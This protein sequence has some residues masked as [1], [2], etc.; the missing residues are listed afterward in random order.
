MIRIGWVNLSSGLLLDKKMAA[1]AKSE[2]NAEMPVNWMKM[3]VIGWQGCP[4]EHS[5]VP[6]NS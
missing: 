4:G 3:S 1:R 2:S 5:N 6:A